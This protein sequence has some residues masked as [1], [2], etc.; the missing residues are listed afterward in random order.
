M[1]KLDPDKLAL[2][3]KDYVFS[4]KTLKMM[5]IVEKSALPDVPPT[6]DFAKGRRP[7]QFGLWGNDAYGDCV[8]VAKYNHVLRLARLDRRRTLKITD[9]MVVGE[10]KTDTGCQVAGDANDSGLVMLD[11][12][13]RWLHTENTVPQGAK[14]KPFP[15]GIEAYGEIGH[16]HQHM[17]AATF[18]LGGI[19]FGLALPYTAAEE[20][21]SGKPWDDT[22]SSDPDAQPGSW[23][24]HAVYSER[25]DENGFWVV[26]WG[27][28]HYMTNAFVDR[29]SDERWAVVDKVE[30]KRY[31]NQGLLDRY[32]ADLG[33]KSGT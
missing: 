18:L 23:G 24:G 22:H 7:L 15:I 27:E 14:S 30:G 25:Y 1:T 3:K 31:L 9:D 21:Q 28:E 2:G 20:L 19:E 26:T 17:R 11:N 13:G 8:K 32:F 16:D 12:F 5:S 33:I 10:Y 6:Y 4:E 29:Y